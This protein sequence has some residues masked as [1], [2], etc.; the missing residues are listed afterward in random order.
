MPGPEIT[1][2]MSA[3][4]VDA[5]GKLCEVVFSPQ[6]I[7]QLNQ[8]QAVTSYSPSHPVA[9]WHNDEARAHIERHLAEIDARQ[10]ELRRG[11][12]CLT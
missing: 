6:E 7:E 12:P 2:S 4:W 3:R 10:D 1:W 5:N 9:R 8:G 11:G